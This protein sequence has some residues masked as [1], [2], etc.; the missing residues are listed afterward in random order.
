MWSISTFQCVEDGSPMATSDHTQMMLTS[1][2]G[3]EYDYTTLMGFNF[4][5]KIFYIIIMFVNLKF[6]AKYFF[7]SYIFISLTNSVNLKISI[8]VAL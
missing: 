8:I 3:A 1:M 5:Y 6:L 7:G 2:L 4:L